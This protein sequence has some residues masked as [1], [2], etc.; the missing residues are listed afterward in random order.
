MGSDPIT[1]MG[2]NILP[3]AKGVGLALVVAGIG[4]MIYRRWDD[5]RRGLR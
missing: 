1:M 5:K 4:Y 2:M 3:I